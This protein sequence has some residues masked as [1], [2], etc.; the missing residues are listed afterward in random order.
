[1][2]LYQ[3]CIHIWSND[4]ALTLTLDA[5][6]IKKLRIKF[7][8]MVAGSFNVEKHWT[9]RIK[10]EANR[11]GLIQCNQ[12]TASNSWVSNPPPFWRGYE[13]TQA[14][15]LRANSLPTKGNM[16]VPEGQRYCRAG[17]PGR[18]ETLCHIRQASSRSHNARM[19]RHN[20]IAKILMNKAKVINSQ[21]LWEPPITLASGEQKRPDLVITKGKE[22]WI[23]DV[24]VFWGEP[25]ALATT[26]DSKNKVY[27]KPEIIQATAEK[28]D[29][30][31]AGVKVESCIV[32]ARGIWPKANLPDEKFLRLTHFDK[33]R[34]TSDA[35]QWGVHSHKDFMR[36]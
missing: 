9:D 31:E 14:I 25:N 20:H 8:K 36:S 7:E 27:N 17:N 19:Q 4:R 15:K 11:R 12:D 24:E 26:R 22:A 28:I 21:V 2:Q 16:S 10:G 34:I 33:C 35:L 13:Y 3:T 1:M 30:P 32:G 29:L 6:R 5:E 23:I 18:I